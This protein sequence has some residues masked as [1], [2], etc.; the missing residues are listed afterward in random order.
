M[1]KNIKKT[2]IEIVLE[3]QQLK[4]SELARRLDWTKQ[5]IGYLTSPLNKSFPLDLLYHIKKSLNLSDKELY[6]IIR[7]YLSQF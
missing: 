6:Q 7:E 1:K 4:K 3:Q 5:R 2:F